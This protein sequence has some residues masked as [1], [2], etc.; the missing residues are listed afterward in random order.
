MSDLKPCPFCGCEMRITQDKHR[1]FGPDGNH[2]KSCML[3]YDLHDYAEGYTDLLVRDWNARSSDATI[4]AQAAEIARL[5]EALQE[6]KR[7]LSYANQ[8]AVNEVT[9]QVNQNKAWHKARAALK[10]ADNATGE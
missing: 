2:S 9:A 7:L 3:N 8:D 6:V 1:L 10:G 5:R 4:E